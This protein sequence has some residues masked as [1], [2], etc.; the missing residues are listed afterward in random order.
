MQGEVRVAGLFASEMR[1][2]RE[3]AGLTRE[4]LAEAVAFSVSL[5]EKVES[6]N[7]Q[8]SE[9]FANAVDTV[10]KTDGLL[11]RLR[12]GLL[13][14]DAVP[15][16][17]RPWPDIEDQASEI[18]W[19]EPLVVPG[20]MQTKAYAMALLGDDNT[21][22]ARIERQRVFARD[23]P[24]EVVIVLDEAVLHRQ[25]GDS[26]TMHEQL[27][28]LAESP[29]CVQILPTGA[30][31]YLGVDGSFVLA[32]V[33]DRVLAYVETP[34]TGLVLDD[35][36]TT[37]RL[38]RRWDELRGESLPQRQSRKMILEVAEQWKTRSN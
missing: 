36:D 33:D 38:G 30:D 10:L 15:P 6:G 31:T 22:E 12:K 20:L 23:A 32:R 25:V 21:V 34:A 8:P 26:Q 17:F 37:A 7:K 18:R 5:I 24:P 28:S 19:Y 29:A 16:W 13:Q 4:Q 3:K 9:Q 27:V 14:H 2:A 1:R 35:N 11:S